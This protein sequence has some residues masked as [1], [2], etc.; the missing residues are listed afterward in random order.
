MRGASSASSE[1]P[2]A[3][4]WGARLALGAVAVAGSAAYAASFA[5]APQAGEA[6]RLARP[7]AIAAGLSWPAFGAALLLATRRRPSVLA[8][9]DACLVTMAP[10]IGVLLLSALLN[11]LHR[12][13]TPAHGLVLLLSNAAM[14]GVFVSR[15]RRLGMRA[16]LAVALWVGVLDGAFLLLLWVMT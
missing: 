12:G 1:R 15:A 3:L 16:P 14:A 10:G 13:T 4:S 9:A 8:W 2:A 11:L 5:W 6:V 7:I